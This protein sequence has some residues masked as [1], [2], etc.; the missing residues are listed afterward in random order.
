MLVQ[1]RWQAGERLGGA[2]PRHPGAH[3][4]P[5]DQL[6]QVGG[7]ALVLVRAGAESEAVAEGEHHRAL[8]QTLEL[9]VLA[10][11]GQR[12]GQQ[13]EQSEAKS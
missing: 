9:G 8:G 12:Q 7:V 5:A 1:R 4:A 3:H 10:A 13:C 11:A 6:L 2:L